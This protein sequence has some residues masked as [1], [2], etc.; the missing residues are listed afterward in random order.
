MHFHLV[1]VHSGYTQKDADATLICQEG[2]AILIDTG[3][4]EDAEAILAKMQEYNVE[5]LN[6][7][8]FSHGDKEHIGSAGEI[9]KTVPVETVIAPYYTGSD[10]M[11]ELL[12]EI[13][14]SGIPILYPAHNMHI[15]GGEI[16]INCYPALEKHYSDENNYSLAVLIKHHEVSMLFTGDAL[17]IRS[18]ELRRIHWKNISLYKVP[19]HG[20]SN[21]QSIPLFEDVN[22]GIAVVTSDEC[23]RDITEVANK[24]NST[25]LFTRPDG[26][27]FVSDGKTLTY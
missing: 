16:D 15:S 14:D 20:R 11:K 4:E 1:W 12:R 25:L 22:P 19:H 13:K 24:C 10:D 23:D 7:L 26:L 2:F 8:I 3:E 9:L 21:S 6:Y 18:E 27:S 5:K 17:R